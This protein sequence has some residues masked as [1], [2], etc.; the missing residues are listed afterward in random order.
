MK[1]KAYLEH[2]VHSPQETPCNSTK[3]NTL[4]TAD[5]TRKIFMNNSFGLALH[6][7]RNIGLL[8]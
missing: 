2:G 8:N 1:V 4:G 3:E 5:G 7:S 6:F